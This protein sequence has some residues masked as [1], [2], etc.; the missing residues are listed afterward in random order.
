M[1]IIDCFCGLAMKTMI[2]NIILHFQLNRLDLVRL[3]NEES[4]NSE[5]LWN[6]QI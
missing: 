5:S 6:I 4:Q 2:L 3:F 1:I